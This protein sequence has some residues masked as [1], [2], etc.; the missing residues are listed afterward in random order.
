MS[1]CL[2]TKM[3]ISSRY[4]KKKCYVR[5]EKKNTVKDSEVS[6]DILPRLDLVM[7][8]SLL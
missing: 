2:Q 4:R 1:L 6:G 5:L 3:K 7:Y 8:P